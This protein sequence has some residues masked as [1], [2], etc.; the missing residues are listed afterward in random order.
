MNYIAFCSRLVQ[1]HGQ[2]VQQC[3]FWYLTDGQPLFVK[4]L[5]AVI[6]LTGILT[7]SYVFFKLTY[8]KIIYHKKHNKPYKAKDIKM[9][10]YYIFLFIVF[11]IPAIWFVFSLLK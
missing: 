3:N 11:F 7:L 5:L 9:L 6:L 2:L 10:S 8:I 1:F 4:L